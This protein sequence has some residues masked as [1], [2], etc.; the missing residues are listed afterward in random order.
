MTLVFLLGMLA[1]GAIALA[2]FIAGGIFATRSSLNSPA[3]R[4]ELMARA[5]QIIAKQYRCT[6][7][8]IV[9]KVDLN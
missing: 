3:G 8:V 2:C 1:G 9:R 7:T 4:E 5:A 6:A